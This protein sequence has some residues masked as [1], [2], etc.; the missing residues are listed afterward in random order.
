[1]AAEGIQTHNRQ[2]ILP[3][4][5]WHSNHSAKPLPLCENVSKTYQIMI[6]F[7][8]YTPNNFYAKGITLQLIVEYN[9]IMAEKKVLG[10]GADVKFVVRHEFRS[11]NIYLYTD[12]WKKF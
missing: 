6:D 2:A 3:L 12:P 4:Q 1:M 9:N 8:Y 11:E 5:V 10:F 7:M